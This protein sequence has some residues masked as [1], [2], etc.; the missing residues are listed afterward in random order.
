MTHNQINQAI[1]LKRKSK[2]D[3]NARMTTML[4]AGIEKQMSKIS[5]GIILAKGPNTVED[6][7]KREE[8]RME[9]NC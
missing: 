4:E 2:T 1:L 7:I 6:S 9:I 8:R 3:L 5:K